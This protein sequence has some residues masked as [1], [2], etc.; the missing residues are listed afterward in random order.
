MFEQPTYLI[1]IGHNG[2]R[3]AIDNLNREIGDG[4]ILSPADYTKEK[5]K[6][7]S[8][9]IKSAG[10]TVLFDPQYYIPRTERP[11]LDTYDY[12][13][14]YGGG[15]FDTAGVGQELGELCQRIVDV[16]D[17]LGV[18]AYIAPARLL[19]TFS[20]AK[21][22]EWE[23]MVSAFMSAAAENGR[24][25]PIL[26]S[27]PLYYKSLVDVEQRRDLLN[28]ITRYDVDG[29]Y[30]SVEF[31]KDSRYPLTGSSNVYSLL[32]L[33]NVLRKNRYKVLAGHTHQIAHLLFG[34][35]ITAFASGHYQNLR[36][37]DTRRW[38]PEDQQGGG[39][40]VVKY[41]TDKLLNDLRVDPEL[42]LMYQK[43][44]FDMEAIRTPSPYD[45]SLFDSSIP[46]SA[47][48]WKLRD[49]SWDHYI[50]S[51]HQIAERYRG[52]SLAERTDL[53]EKKIAEAK[54]L[55]DQISEQFGM[56]SEP[57]PDIYSDWDDALSL[58]KK[59]L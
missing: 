46:P 6:E 43:S 33:L 49:G 51:C 34:I 32:H 10:K 19:D 48:G 41:Y 17:Y 25:I 18:S 11:R 30:V 14:E 26:A 44:D 29:F 9:S 47:V 58:I 5:N 52:N 27:L 40:I 3:L 22:S 42:D 7:I 45:G 24:D 53:A 31:E 1:Q 59:D 2:H 16:Q 13:I 28:R 20:D 12:F 15:D 50:W 23:E 39:R 36:S 37:F 21:V 35:G 54:A 38:E 55:H 4:A 57:D 8:E 56:L